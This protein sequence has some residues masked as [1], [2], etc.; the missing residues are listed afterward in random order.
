M[1]GQEIGRFDSC[2]YSDVPCFCSC[3]CL[4]CVCL[5]CGSLMS[6]IASVLE[7]NFLVV[8]VDYSVTCLILWKLQNWKHC[9][10]N[11]KLR[12]GMRIQQIA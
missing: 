12:S 6:S 10:E 2:I 4:A 7:I 11:M 1:D 8:E 5:V 3:V 9:S